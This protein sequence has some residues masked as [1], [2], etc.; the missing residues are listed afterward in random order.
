MRKSNAR[1]K[2]IDSGGSG[3]G[4]YSLFGLAIFGLAVVSNTPNTSLDIW[5]EQCNGVQ[6]WNYIPSLAQKKPKYCRG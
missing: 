5:I 3:S 6:E 4:G 1:A 2:Y